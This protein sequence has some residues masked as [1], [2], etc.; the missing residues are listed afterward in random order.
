MEKGEAIE[1][2]DNIWIKKGN[3]IF[4]NKIRPL[5]SDL[6]NLPFP[7][8]EIFDYANLNL[9]KRGIGTFMFSRGCPYQCA[10]CCEP[11]LSK[12]YPNPQNYH[13]FRSV[14]STVNEIKEVIKNY[15]FIK[16]IRMD[17]D[18]LFAKREW[19]KEFVPLYRKEIGL[20]FSTD[21]RVNLIDDN[22]LTLIKEAG[23]HL[24]RIGVESGDNFIL[25]EVLN[26]G[27]TVEQIKKAFKIAKEKNIK[28]QAYNMI[29]VPYE[30]AKEILATIK[31]NAQIKPDLSVVS[32][33]HPYR[34][35]YLY[36]LCCQK[37]FLI[38]NENL[39]VPRNYYSCSI[40]SLPTIRKEQITFFFRYFHLLKNFYS[41]LFK[42]PFAKPLIFAADS[43]F[44]LKY[45]PEAASVTI[46]PL[47]LI[48]RKIL[49]KIKKRKIDTEAI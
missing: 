30:G 3:K 7:D 8:R 40:L 47:R 10:F 31:L 29:G 19:V 33:F 18:L 48:M 9:E 17:D 42:I 21:M 46:G 39:E 22:L 11:T 37:D 35:T 49:T 45:I 43:L 15:P 28:V 23:G 1:N 14:Q 25:K 38:E 32:I 16:F 26:K 6:N 20:P 12:I 27:I 44:S 34:G 24:L 5:I 4:R 41:L 36:E 13:R 2:V